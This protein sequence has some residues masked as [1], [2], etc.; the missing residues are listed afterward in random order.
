LE[1]YF[2]YIYLFLK[3]KKIPVQ[4]SKHTYNN[5]IFVIVLLKP[6]VII[7]KTIL[8]ILKKKFI[9]F[10]N[11]KKLPIHVVFDQIIKNIIETT[12]EK[13]LSVVLCAA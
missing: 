9:G 1:T 7:T 2:I 11:A 5:R 10:L 8:N 13:N 12:Y 6:P 4:N 3:Q